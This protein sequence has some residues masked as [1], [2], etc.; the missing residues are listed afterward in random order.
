MKTNNLLKVTL[1]AVAMFIA[2]GLMAQGSA[3]PGQAVP[4]NYATE[5]I[6]IGRGLAAIKVNK[7]VL[8]PFL[9]YLL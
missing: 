1:A 3:I 4:V 2:V 6:C 5:H 9:F 8:N 7:K